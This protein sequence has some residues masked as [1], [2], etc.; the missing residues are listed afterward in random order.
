MFAGGKRPEKIV[1]NGNDLVREMDGMTRVATEIV[2]RL[3]HLL[4]PGCAEVV[5]KDKTALAAIMELK[6]IKVIQ[7]KW[8]MAKWE[9]IHLDLYCMLDH[10]W[11]LRFRNRAGR[12]KGI[13]YLHDLIPITFYGADFADGKKDTVKTAGKQYERNLRRMKKNAE[14]IVTVS[15]YSKQEILRYLD[16][17]KDRVVVVPNGWE[18]YEE[19]EPN[20]RIFEKF[21]KLKEEPYFFSLGGISPHKNF[22]LICKLAKSNKNANF[23][24]AGDVNRGLETEVP[25][26]KNLIF[27]GRLTDG[28]IKALMEG[29]RAFIFPSLA[30]GMGLPHLE[31]LSCGADV[32]VSDIP[33]M[34]EVCG[35]SVRY[36]DPRNGEVDLETLL[37]EQ[38]ELPQKVLERFSW[39]LA[40]EKISN[41]ILEALGRGEQ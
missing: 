35:G 16:V 28:E 26:L 19:I 9:L 25:D 10:A 7:R 37:A 11:E 40:A 2:R 24:I 12:A 6:N 14:K 33:V 15:E 30:E 39:D 29:C 17:E 22:G 32:L 5:V 3:D 38:V 8:P 21:P 27:T 1:I 41:L 36:F 20:E 4:P 18:H 13:Y 34:H 31:A 23:V